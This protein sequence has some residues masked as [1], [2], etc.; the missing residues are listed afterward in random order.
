MGESSKVDAPQRHFDAPGA[1]VGFSGEFVLVPAAIARLVAQDAVSALAARA[2]RAAGL[3]GLG[4]GPGSGEVAVEKVGRPGSQVDARRIL[5]IHMAIFSGPTALGNGGVPDEHR[6]LGAPRMGLVLAAD[7]GLDGQEIG[8]V[9][10]ERLSVVASAV[11]VLRVGVHVA[12]HPVL[13]DFP[14]VGDEVS[15]VAGQ[16][17]GE[18]FSEGFIYE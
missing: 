11:E 12:R 10:R 1:A 9:P 15:M 2:I 18:A 16:T 8:L 7:E 3:E 4:V 17:S 13:D 14:A 6:D 5:A